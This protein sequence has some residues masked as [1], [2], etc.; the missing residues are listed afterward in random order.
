MRQQLEQKLGQKKLI[1]KLLQQLE[2]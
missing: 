1:F 2:K